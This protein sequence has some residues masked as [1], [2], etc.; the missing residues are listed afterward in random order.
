MSQQTHGWRQSR[1]LVEWLADEP[2]RFEFYQ[3]V[4]ILEAIQPHITV[5]GFEHAQ[6]RPDVIRFRSQIGFGFP[7]SEVQEL[8]LGNGSPELTVNVFGLAGALGPLP[9]P[10]TE[11]VLDAAA[12]KEHAAADF[13]DIFNHRLIYL[14][15]C[16]RRAHEPALTAIAPHRGSP[17]EYLFAI[18]GLAGG[19][20]R[21]KLGFPAQSLL[22]YSGLLARQPRTAT[23]LEVMLRDY[24]GVRLTV[25]QFSGIWRRIDKSQWTKIG[26]SGQNRT[27]G[28]NA[29]LGNHAWD[30]AG[31]ITIVIGPLGISDFLGFLP[32]ARNHPTLCALVSFYIGTDRKARVRVILN[33][34]EVPQLKLGQSRLGYTSWIRARPYTK[35]EASAGFKLED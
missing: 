16:V 21:A 20:S 24:F 5:P 23:G 26:Y 8:A 2:Y 9:H 18:I 4:R 12:R 6:P 14:L 31:A 29:A 25:Q 34:A 22:H 33:G 1:S 3:A 30:Q 32:G 28:N 17:A 7:A 19:R 11:M 35:P 15:Y 10:Y 13:L 27:L